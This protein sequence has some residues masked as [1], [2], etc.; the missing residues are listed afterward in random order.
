CPTSFFGDWLMTT[1][2]QTRTAALPVEA[3]ATPTRAK[4]TLMQQQRK[5]GWIF[6]SPWIIGF[7]IFTAA[8]IVAS[9]IFTFT[10]FS[11]N[12][13]DPI[14]FVGLK[15]W[16]KLFSDPLAL[17]ALGVTIKFALIAVPIGLLVPLG[18]AALLNSKKLFAKRIWRILF[19]MPYMVPIVSSIFVWQSFL[20][21]QTGWLN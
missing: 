12:T 17:T 7:V 3:T 13:G 14:T 9:F 2:D 8:P 21:G 11:I 15:N 20:G 10:Q 19:Y 1:A 5:W 16:Q 18:L 6:L 4:S